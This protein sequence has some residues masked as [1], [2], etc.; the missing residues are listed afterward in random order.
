MKRSAADFGLRAAQRRAARS[1]SRTG[2]S[3]S[4]IHLSTLS[5][6]ERHTASAEGRVEAYNQAIHAWTSAVASSLRASAA[7]HSKTLAQS[8][9]PRLVA[10]Q[11]GIIHRIGFAFERHGIYLHHGASRGYGGA[12]GSKWNYLRRFGTHR[13]DTGLIRHTRPDS[14]GRASTGNRPAA[15]WFN[16]IIEQHLAALSDLAAQHW[17]TMAVDATQ[18]LI[19]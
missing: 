15:D 18:I 4:L 2:S 19:R 16:P 17:T 8:I 10:D 13:I 12:T 14:I 1:T 9:T 7:L 6:V 11:Y 5:D 3:S